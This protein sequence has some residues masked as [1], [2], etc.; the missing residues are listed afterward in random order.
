M[1]KKALVEEGGG[2]IAGLLDNIESLHSMLKTMD[3]LTVLKECV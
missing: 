1:K 2:S 3:Y